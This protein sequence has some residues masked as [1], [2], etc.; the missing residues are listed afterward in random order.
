MTISALNLPGAEEDIQ[1][2]S[3]VQRPQWMAKHCGKRGKNSRSQRTKM[4]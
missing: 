4:M 1:F 2:F 3:A